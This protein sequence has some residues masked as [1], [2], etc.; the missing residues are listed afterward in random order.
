MQRDPGQRE[1]L[2]TVGRRARIFRLLRDEEEVGEGA[3]LM[4]MGQFPEGTFDASD[5]DWV[6][7][8]VA[9]RLG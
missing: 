5:F 6:K 8:E 1:L 9:P 7:Q 2:E 3:L 4:R